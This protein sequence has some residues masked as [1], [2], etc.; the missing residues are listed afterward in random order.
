MLTLLLG[1]LADF[2]LGVCRAGELCHLCHYGFLQPPHQRA[3]CL[4]SSLVNELE[5]GGGDGFEAVHILVCNCLCV[6]DN[7]DP[8]IQ[9]PLLS[10]FTSNSPGTSCRSLFLTVHFSHLSLPSLCL[11]CCPALSLFF[12]PAGCRFFNLVSIFG[13]RPSLFL[14]WTLTHP[15][16]LPVFLKI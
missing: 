10:A 2:L 3:D 12:F 13:S 8:G 1:H 7:N 15:L 6:H 11:T 9:C 5:G 14:Y 16:H 4:L